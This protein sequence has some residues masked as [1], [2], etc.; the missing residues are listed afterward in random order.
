M[1]MLMAYF[2]FEVIDQNFYS[3]AKRVRETLSRSNLL[4]SAFMEDI[5]D[6]ESVSDI[7]KNISN[8]AK[9]YVSPENKE[10]CDKIKL[11]NL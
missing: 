9:K 6:T 8:N 5:A 3:I 1:M 7:L 4:W 11:W 2:F 10:I